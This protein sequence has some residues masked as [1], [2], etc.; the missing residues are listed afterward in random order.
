VELKNKNVRRL[1]PQDRIECLDITLREVVL[2][3]YKGERSDL[4]FANFFVLNAKVLEV[5]EIGIMNTSYEISEEWKADQSRRLRLDSRAS[6]N[7]RF[8][9]GDSY[10]YTKFACSKHSHVLTIVDPVGSSCGICGPC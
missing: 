6:R 4:N 1:T 5:M 10:P 8:Y 7:A 2:K 3:G 9:F